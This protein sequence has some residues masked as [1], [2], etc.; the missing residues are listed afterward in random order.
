MGDD[1]DLAVLGDLGHGSGVDAPT[2]TSSVGEVE[3]QDGAEAV[4]VHAGV[5]LSP[6]LRE[7]LRQPELHDKLGHVG[8]PNSTEFSLSWKA[9]KKFLGPRREGMLDVL[10]GNDQCEIKGM[11]Y[12][13]RRY[14][15]LMAHLH[16]VEDQ[17]RVKLSEKRNFWLTLLT[18]VLVVVAPL[19]FF[20]AYW[21]MNFDNMTEYEVEQ[22]ESMTGVGVVWHTWVIVY[23]VAL[24]VAL[25]FRLFE[26]M[27]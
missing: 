3:M 17:Y 23:S 1:G 16:R 20:T 12:W 8:P 25:H 18:L 11:E 27:F 14:D 6:S 5:Q 21:S 15:G 10:R 19:M 7:G 4:P 9:L 2:S 26:K 13:A 24:V 22:G